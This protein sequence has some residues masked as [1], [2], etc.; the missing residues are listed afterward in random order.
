M[1]LY[2]YVLSFYIINLPTVFYVNIDIF[3]K[4][5]IFYN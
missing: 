3:K 4:F 2:S 5:Q 1:L